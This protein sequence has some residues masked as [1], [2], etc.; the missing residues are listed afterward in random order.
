MVAR[1]MAAAVGGGE[2]LRVP[3]LHISLRGRNHVVINNKSKEKNGGT[4]G[5]A[6]AK[7]K[8]RKTQLK[9]NRGDKEYVFT[10]DVSDGVE[11]P[12]TGP[13]GH[14]ALKNSVSMQR[15]MKKAK[16]NSTY[17]QLFQGE[18]KVRETEFRLF[19]KCR[20]ADIFFL[21]AAILKRQQIREDV[22]KRKIA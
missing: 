6:T 13:L 9:N 21:T 14:E 10:D 5:A 2:E 18:E 11:S 19:V 22:T 16:M 17:E 8:I 7:M 4:D 20:L 1:T 12:T 3:P 15:K